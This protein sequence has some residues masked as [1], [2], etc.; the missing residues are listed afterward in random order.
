MKKLF[1]GSMMVIAM[2]AAVGSGGPVHGEENGNDKV[3]IPDYS[4]RANVFGELG[5]QEPEESF[6]PS[7]NQLGTLNYMTVF[8]SG[9]GSFGS[10]HGFQYMNNVKELDGG[11]NDNIQDFRPISGMTSLER[12]N[13]SMNVFEDRDSAVDISFAQHLPNLKEFVFEYNVLDLTPLNEIENLKKISVGNWGDRNI[14]KGSQQI[15]SR[16]TKEFM[17]VNPVTYS[18][19]F[20]DID[21]TVTAVDTSGNLL[22]VSVSEDEKVFTISD[23]PENMESIKL[24]IEKSNYEVDSNYVQHISMYNVPLYWN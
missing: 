15:V 21:L 6:I 13:M 1:V 20:E 14:V 10:L 19:Q 16:S 11:Y 22:D 17:M 3:Y 8:G 4:I 2:L 24:Q 23:I 7:I 18:T 5:I 9:D 12:I